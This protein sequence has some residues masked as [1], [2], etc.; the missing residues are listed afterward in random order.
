MI[1]RFSVM[2]LVMVSLSGCRSS[3]LKHL[4]NYQFNNNGVPDYSSLNYWAAHPYKHDPSDSVPEP[5]RNNYR[6]DSSVD[7]FFIHPTTFTDQTLPEWNADI[8]DAKLNAKTD[9]ST[10]LFQASV[11][12]Q[13]RVFAPRYRQANL[14]GYY[15]ND[16]DNAKKAFDLAYEDVKSAF[17][18][19][20]DHEN[21]GHLII[22]AAHSQGSTHAIRLLR[23]FFDGKDLEKKLVVAY[24]VGMNI[25]KNSFVNIKPCVDSLQTGCVCGWRTYRNGT[26]PMMNYPYRESLITN[27]LNWKA[28]EA[29]APAELNKGAVLRKFNKVY[30]QATDAQIHENILWARRPHFFG[31]FLYRS[32]NYHIGDINL[33]YLNIRE[34]VNARIRAFRNE[35]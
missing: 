9:Y 18:Y 5:L 16:V 22:I 21:N 15:T 28:D 2:I 32:K 12:N 33:F 10:I 17:Q 27:P 11:F 3:Y 31:S 6:P 13:Q 26:E 35:R 4:S 8:N 30:G 29:Y 14:R 1:R 24:V 23:E 19:Y 34:N 7:V 25:P 20:L